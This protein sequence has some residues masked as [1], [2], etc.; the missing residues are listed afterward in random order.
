MLAIWYVVYGVVG[1][2]C[3]AHAID[4]AAYLHGGQFADNKAV[5]GW[6]AVAALLIGSTLL[7]LQIL[8]ASPMK[9]K[10]GVFDL[11]SFVTGVAVSCAIWPHVLVAI[12]VQ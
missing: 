8:Y 10:T 4:F 11:M 12:G 2:A 5:L 7:V 3:L 6:L 1:G 9:K